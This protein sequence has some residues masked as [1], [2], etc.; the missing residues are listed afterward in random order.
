MKFWL[1][2][3]WLSLTPRVQKSPWFWAPMK[4]QLFPT[5]AEAPKNLEKME[6]ETLRSPTETSNRLE[7]RW[8]PEIILK[9]KMKNQKSKSETPRGIVILKIRFWIWI[10]TWIRF[11]SERSE[12]R[13]SV[14]S[15][16]EQL[17][18][19][20]GLDIQNSLARHKW[21]SIGKINFPSIN[22]SE[23]LI[24]KDQ[25]L[26]KHYLESINGLKYLFNHFTSGMNPFL[27]NIILFSTDT[28][29][30]V[31]LQSLKELDR[32]NNIQDFCIKAFDFK[33]GFQDWSYLSEGFYMAHLVRSL[34]CS[35][36]DQVLALEL[37]RPQAWPI[38]PSFFLWNGMMTKLESSSSLHHQLVFASHSPHFSSYCKVMHTIGKLC[39]RAFIWAQI[40]AEKSKNRVQNGPKTNFRQAKIWWEL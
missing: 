29:S 15:G 22:T 14:E 24:I 33:Y 38:Q 34:S 32:I 18:W 27:V 12:P 35:V 2:L 30:E 31:D 40:W 10:W 36:L 28:W 16:I 17:S 20:I 25:A 11:L 1:W 37:A 9:T 39:S 23:G 26:V 6:M 8:N 3:K 5:F 7:N 19:I 4:I 13:L 21:D